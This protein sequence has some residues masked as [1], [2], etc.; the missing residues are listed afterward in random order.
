MDTDDLMIDL[1]P[2]TNV[3][4]LVMLHWDDRPT[5]GTGDRAN[6]CAESGSGSVLTGRLISRA[7][8]DQFDQILKWANSKG[9]W[10][11]ITARASI[12]AGEVIDGV[13]A[14]NVF[15]D[16][17]LRNRFVRMWQ[18]VAA[19]YRSFDGIAAYEVLSEPR[20]RPSD[21]D[22][23]AE[24]VRSF[25][26]AACAAVHAE[27]PRTPC[28]IGAAPYYRSTS[29]Q[30]VFL[31]DATGPMIYAFNFFSP[32]AYVNG[33]LADQA[34]PGSMRCCD[35]YGSGWH[36][37][38]CCAEQCCDTLVRF[39]RDL[40]ALE[41][42]RPLDFSRTRRVPVLLDQWGV[43]RDA[44][45]RDAYLS[46]MQ[47]LLRAEGVHWTYWQWRQREFSVF[48]VVRFGKDWRLPDVDHETVASLSASLGDDER[49]VAA[50]PRCDFLRW[51]RDL[52]GCSSLAGSRRACSLAYVSMSGRDAPCGYVDGRCVQLEAQACDA[53]RASMP[54]RATP[55]PPPPPPSP[56]PPLPSSS[57]PP[58]P[59]PPPPLPQMAL[60]SSAQPPRYGVVSAPISIVTVTQAASPPSE[61]LFSPMDA[62]AATAAPPSPPPLSVRLA[63]PGSEGVGTGTSSGLAATQTLAVMLFGLLS[64]LLVCRRHQGHGH[65]TGKYAPVAKAAA[66]EHESLE[67]I[68]R[69]PN[70]RAQRN[71]NH[72]ERIFEAAEAT[73]EL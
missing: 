29:L 50:A 12:A 23:V 10:S 67:G 65:W 66:L 28:M 19:R 18:Q 71:A 34:Y 3:V 17:A 73:Y 35:A 37:A 72:V 7:C 11:I 14:P 47:D 56:P 70:Q 52:H 26:A 13:A 42:S 63:I 48:T 55:P 32:K 2:G 9:L 20:V 33:L 53:A 64:A 43:Q 4:R 54:P 69:Q 62:L 58:P 44:I 68:G 51:R 27:D 59:P 31:A 22:G 5:E 57:P 21:G 36:E 40:L 38:K 45:G 30:D 25:Y 15:T 8:L 6:D 39:D 60:R 24:S 16:M 49:V 41:L 46:D 1:L 61:R